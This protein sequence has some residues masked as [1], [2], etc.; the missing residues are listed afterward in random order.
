MAIEAI[1]YLIQINNIIN[2][3][4]NEVIKKPIKMQM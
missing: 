2:I 3:M 4:K 1:P